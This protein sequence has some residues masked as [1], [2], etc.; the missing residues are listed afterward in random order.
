MTS[1]MYGV[2][3]GQTLSVK[4]KCTGAESKLSECKRDKLKINDLH[5]FADVGVICNI[6]KEIMILFCEIIIN[7][8]QLKNNIYSYKNT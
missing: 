8:S 2:G 6:R 5:H 7:R 4:I 3:S 1:D